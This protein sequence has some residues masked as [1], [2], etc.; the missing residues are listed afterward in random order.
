MSAMAGPV[1]AASSACPSDGQLESLQSMAPEQIPAELALHL[2]ACGRCQRRLL[3]GAPAG[4]QRSRQPPSLGRALVLVGV[5]LI[6]LLLL[7]ISLQKLTS[8]LD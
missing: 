7:L 6:A 4:R 8:L 5:V 3:F 1:P 2:A